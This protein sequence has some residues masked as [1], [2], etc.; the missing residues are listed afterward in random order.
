MVHHL[1]S[2]IA[3]FEK[4]L[5]L[6]KN[7]IENQNF[8]NFPR[9]SQQS[10]NEAS[11]ERYISEL[12]SLQEQFGKRLQDLRQYEGKFRLYSTL[13]LPTCSQFRKDFKI[14]PIRDGGVRFDLHFFGSRRVKNGFFDC[15]ESF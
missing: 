9:L 11:T 14:N 7:Q 10:V 8:V 2:L 6:W 1:Y 12:S 4:R 15:S 3:V 13:F 5:D